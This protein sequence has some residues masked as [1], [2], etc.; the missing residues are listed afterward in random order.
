MFEI[1]TVLFKLYG[2]GINQFV[3]IPPC[4]AATELTKEYNA[5]PNFAVIL[6]PNGEKLAS[7]SGAESAAD[8]IL[9]YLEEHRDH[10]RSYKK[11][12]AK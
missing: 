2:A 3:K 9:K 10:L 12:A 4:D 8:K 1:K 5:A 11:T 6:A 7:F